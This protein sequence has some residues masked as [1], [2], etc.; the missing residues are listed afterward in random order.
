MLFITKLFKLATDT[1]P[2]PRLLVRIFCTGLLISFLGTLPLGTLNVLAAKMAVED[3]IRPAIWFSLGALIVEMGYVRLSL[4]AMDW[5]RRQRKWIKILEILTVMIILFLAAGSFWAAAHPSRGSNIVLGF[6]SP[7]PIPRFLTGMVLSAI[8]PL[9][10]PFW[11]GWSTVLFNKKILQ[12]RRDH[13]NVY[14]TGI[15]LGTFAGNAV[16]IFGGRFLITALGMHQA[17]VNIVIGVIFA[18]TALWQIIRPPTYPGPP[19]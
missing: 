16:F 5:I 11:F 10:I 14:I 3:G 7:A 8:N 4:V 13:Y 18:V 9:Q 6:I 12:P 1:P 2:G 19:G 15:G 17:L